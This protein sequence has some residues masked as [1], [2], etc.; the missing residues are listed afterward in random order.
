MSFHIISF[1]QDSEWCCLFDSNL[2]D[3]YTL[4]GNN[5][6]GDIEEEKYIFQD[7]ITELFLAISI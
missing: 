5:F 3:D 6:K 1:I 7:Q 2:S 4:Q